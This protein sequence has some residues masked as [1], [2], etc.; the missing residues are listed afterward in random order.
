MSNTPSDLKY[1]SSHEWARLDG[2]VVTVGITDHA[3]EALGDL[4]YV[5]LPDVGDTVAAGDEAGVVESVKAASD[6]YAP[7]SGEIIAVNEA[8]G[9][10]PEIINTDPYNEGWIYKIRVSDVSELDNL[11]SG[12]EYDAQV[13]TEH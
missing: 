10:T 5:E 2:D 13:A 6:I 3:Q 9:D 12:E 1:A 4:V 8:L 7:V 11:M